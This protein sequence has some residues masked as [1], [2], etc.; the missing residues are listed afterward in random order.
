MIDSLTSSFLYFSTEEMNKY[1]YNF[2]QC[3]EM[4]AQQ[5]CIWDVITFRAIFHEDSN[6]HSSYTAVNIMT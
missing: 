3:V 5:N 1:T 6:R 2:Q 4:R